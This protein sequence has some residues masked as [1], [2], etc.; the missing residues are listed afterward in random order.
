MYAN[1]LDYSIY[2]MY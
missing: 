2:E 1:S